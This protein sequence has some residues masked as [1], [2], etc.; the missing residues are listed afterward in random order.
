M[1]D[2]FI[3]VVTK[4]LRLSKGCCIPP[5]LLWGLLLLL[6]TLSPLPPW[7]L[8]LQQQQTRWRSKGSQP[9][10]SQQMSCEVKSPRENGGWCSKLEKSGMYSHAVEESEFDK[11]YCQNF[12]DTK[13]ILKKIY[14]DH[15]YTYFLDTCCHWSM[16]RE[17]GS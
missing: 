9:G 7:R 16:I 3:S 14:K 6:A 1:I 17:R 5:L 2:V 13:T 8:S 4:P 11:Q 12:E 15:I 10:E